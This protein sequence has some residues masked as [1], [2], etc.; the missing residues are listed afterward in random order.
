[1]LWSVRIDGQRADTR[2]V[3]RL[4]DT[5]DWPLEDGRPA[6]LDAASGGAA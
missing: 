3:L 1:M 4:T 6:V 2:F 5:G